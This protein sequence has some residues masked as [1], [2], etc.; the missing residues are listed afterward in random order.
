MHGSSYMINIRP[1]QSVRQVRNQNCFILVFEVRPQ[2]ISSALGV[3]AQDQ[4]KK[5]DSNSNYH[6]KRNAFI[7]KAKIMNTLSQLCSFLLFS[8]ALVLPTGRGESNA[9]GVLTDRLLAKPQPSPSNI[10]AGCVARYC[11]EEMAKTLKYAH[12]L[13]FSQRTIRDFAKSVK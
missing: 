11:A 3:V 10:N 9:R 8:I 12:Q 6:L 4:K 13:T 2:K 7:H 5:K 1:R